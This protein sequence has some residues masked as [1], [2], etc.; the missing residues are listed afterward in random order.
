[1]I[2]DACADPFAHK[3]MIDD[4]CA[5]PFAHK[6]M[7]D[8]ACEDPFAHKAMIDDACADPF[9]HKAMIDDACATPS[10]TRAMID[11]ACA[12]PYAHKA[13]IDDACADPYAHKVLLQL[14]SPSNKLYLTP[15]LLNQPPRTETGSSVKMLTDTEGDKDEFDVLADSMAVEEEDDG[16]DN[17][18]NFTMSALL[19]TL[20]DYHFCSLISRMSLTCWLTAWRS[21][22]RTMATF[23]NCKHEF[24]A[25]AYSMAVDEEDDGDDNFGN[26]TMSALLL[27]LIDYICLT[28]ISR[29]GL[30][31]LCLFGADELGDSVADSMAV[32]EED[33]GDD[34]FTKKEPKD[35]KAKKD[36]APKDKKPADADAEDADED[37]SDKNSAPSTQTRI[38]GV[39]KKDPVQRRTELL[40]KADG[41]GALL[42]DVD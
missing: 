7:I 14:L 11:D 21:R 42:V 31:H 25:L 41:L 18:G 15:S 38:L 17:F 8:D 5:D 32:D 16:N 6:A 34:M 35:K 29:G 30:T 33:D 39:S 27:T 9:A 37:A 13:M 1:M 20:I 12:D 40:G 22:K 24:D 36:K 26:F 28:P 4:A 10:P 2:D 19:L 23:G 3:A